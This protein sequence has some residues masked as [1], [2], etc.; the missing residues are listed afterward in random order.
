MSQGRLARISLRQGYGATGARPTKLYH[1]RIPAGKKTS[2]QSV[3][4]SQATTGSQILQ[5]GNRILRMA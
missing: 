2:G 1:Y 5:N 3:L 4:F